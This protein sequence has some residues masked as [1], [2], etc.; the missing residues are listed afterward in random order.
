MKLTPPMIRWRGRARRSLQLAFG[1]LALAAVAWYVRGP[2]L[3]RIGA[4]IVNED[5]LTPADVIVVSNSLARATA[6][7]AALLFKQHTSSHIVMTEWVHDPLVERTRE[8]GIPYLDATA[9]SRLILERSGVPVSAITVLPD[10]V[11]G[12]SAE[13]S[14][15]AAFARRRHPASLLMITARSHTARTKWLLERKLPKIRVSVR[16]SRFDR[17]RADAWWRERDQTRE[18]VTEYLRMANSVVFG[19]FWAR[20]KPEPDRVTALNQGR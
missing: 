20:T 3:A 9:I 15:I 1:L 10:R 8:L 18:T 13:I 12:T 17:F 14:A 5:P 11:D 6:F 7:E 4:L 2:I 19:D 16:G